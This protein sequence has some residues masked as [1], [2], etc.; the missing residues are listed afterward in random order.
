MKHKIYFND[1]LV[2]E[3]KLKSLN[4]E[5]GVMSGRFKTNENY[6]HFKDILC[7][8]LKCR[9]DC[10]LVKKFSLEEQNGKFMIS[11]VLI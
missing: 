6:K 5:D 3:S 8:K 2:G 7:S 11:L 1:E 10:C 4:R 9:V